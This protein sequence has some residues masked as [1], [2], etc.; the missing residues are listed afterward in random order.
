MS[1]EELLQAAKDK[2]AKAE[3]SADL[4]HYKQA[5]I[6]GTKPSKKAQAAYDAL[7]EE[8]QKAIDS[9]VVSFSIPTRISLV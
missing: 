8:A 7:P 1:P 2:A 9:N 5:V 4:A 6:K 3:A